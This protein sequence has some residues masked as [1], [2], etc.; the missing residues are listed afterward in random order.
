MFVHLFKEKSYMLFLTDVSL[1]REIQSQSQ[2]GRI[3]RKSGY[4]NIVYCKLFNSMHLSIVFSH[5]PVFM[6]VMCKV[7]LNFIWS[8]WIL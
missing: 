4:W 7:L 5:K 2:C 3:T 6:S 1:V 8:L